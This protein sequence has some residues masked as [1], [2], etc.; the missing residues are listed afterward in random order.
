MIRQKQPKEVAMM[1]LKTEV[2][3]EKE[4]TIKELAAA[5]Y[6]CAALARELGLTLEEVI[7]DYPELKLKRKS[8]E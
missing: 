3:T 2:D 5:L 7:K 6:Y 1:L 8:R 4:E